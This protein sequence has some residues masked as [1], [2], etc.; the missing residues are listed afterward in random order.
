[1][2]LDKLVTT[3]DLS[4]R[5]ALNRELLQEQ[6]GD[7]AIM[8]LNWPVRAALVLKGVQGVQGGTTWNI[9]EWDKV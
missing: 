6:M 4:Q 7:L 8:P 2:I 3:I 5:I 1:V 9:N